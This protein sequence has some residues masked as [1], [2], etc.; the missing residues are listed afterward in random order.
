M[1]IEL[2]HGVVYLTKVRSGGWYL[3]SILVDE[4]YRGKGVGTRLMEKVMKQ[5]DPP[6]YLLATSELGGDV[7]RL[8]KFYKSFGFVKT[9]QPRYDGLGFNYNMVFCPE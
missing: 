2:A 6:I 8:F 1:K 9:K 5:C 7:K 3:A 4:E